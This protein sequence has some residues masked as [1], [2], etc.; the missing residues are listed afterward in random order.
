MDFV[1]AGRSTSG[2]RSTAVHV[3]EGDRGHLGRI[4]DRAVEGVA[5]DAFGQTEALHVVLRWFG[6]ASQDVTV[7]GPFDG[8]IDASS[9]AGSMEEDRKRESEA[10]VHAVLVAHVVA[11]GEA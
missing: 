10:L 4:F 6:Q 1:C 7:F 2:C 11:P 5:A 3:V 9:F 8:F